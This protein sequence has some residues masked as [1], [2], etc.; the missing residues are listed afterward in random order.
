MLTN[1]MYKLLLLFLAGCYAATIALLWF[2]SAPPLIESRY[3]GTPVRWIS[4]G[5]SSP[6]DIT[7]HPSTIAVVGNAPLSQEQREK[8]RACDFIVRCN[9]AR[10]SSPKDRTDL[11]F[12]RQMEHY[13]TTH[14]GQEKRRSI[15]TIV[16]LYHKR[17]DDVAARVAQ[18]NPHARVGVAQCI[19]PDRR[20]PFDS[21]YVDWSESR[22]GPST[23]FMATATVLTL[24]PGA[25]L[26]VYGIG[27]VGGKSCKDVGE[28]NPLLCGLKLVESEGTLKHTHNPKR[29]VEVVQTLSSRVHY[30]APN[31]QS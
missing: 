26:Y 9:D 13:E 19:P 1:R 2:G 11:L 27:P 7:D 12:V 14:M 16:V 29:E 25:Q 28:P 30:V 21:T 6:W 18:K 10:N 5:D 3:E 23:G 8:I 24:F 31:S 4:R 17:W 15:P 20:L 22:W